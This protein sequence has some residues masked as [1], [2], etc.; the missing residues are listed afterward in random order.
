MTTIK[1]NQA[2][3]KQK[4]E[5]ERNGYSRDM[6]TMG[7]SLFPLVKTWFVVV[8]SSPIQKNLNGCA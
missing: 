2:E 3:T 8:N 4:R 7:S 6:C 5:D 1:R